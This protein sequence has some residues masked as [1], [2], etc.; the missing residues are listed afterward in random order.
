MRKGQGLLEDSDSEDEFEQVDGHRAKIR[1]IGNKAS[2][3]SNNKWNMVK[4]K[5]LSN[6]KM[7]AFAALDK[8]EL[9]K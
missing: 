8:G 9:R 1:E 6:D 3:K 2:H 7:K 4:E 5:I